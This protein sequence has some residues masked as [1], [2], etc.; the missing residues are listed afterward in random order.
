MTGVLCEAADVHLLCSFFLFLSTSLC[1]LCRAADDE[2]KETHFFI[3]FFSLFFPSCIFIQLESFLILSFAQCLFLFFFSFCFVCGALSSFNGH[4]LPLFLIVAAPHHLLE[5][6]SRC[7]RW[8]TRPP[9]PSRLYF[10]FRGGVKRGTSLG[11]RR[12]SKHAHTPTH[13]KNKQT[14]K[15]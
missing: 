10:S 15:R 2:E 3:S 11:V 9:P 1:L 14:N 6:E 4:C 8:F 13:K 12:T 5:S 7:V